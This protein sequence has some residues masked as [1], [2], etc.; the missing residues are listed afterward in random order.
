MTPSD[1]RPLL[2]SAPDV[3]R[4]ALPRAIETP[5]A[6][7]FAALARSRRRRA[8]HPKGRVSAAVL[9]VPGDPRL[10]APWQALDDA[11]AVVRRSRGGGLPE[12]WPDV[13]GIALRCGQ[14][15]LLLSSTLPLLPV[16]PFPFRDPVRCSY[17]SLAPYHCGDATGL[18]IGRFA[19]GGRE[20]RLHL[21]PLRGARIPLAVV[22]VG[23]T[24][25]DPAAERVRFDPWR[26]G[27]GL[28]PAG[29]VHRM[30][31]PAYLASRR[32]TYR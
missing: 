9:S 27:A 21:R 5:I 6:L 23:S 18:I 25:T 15:D 22:R 4:T 2:D 24:V 11:P 26:A 17:S 13:L 7:V 30:R 12:S 16:L 1:L 14:Q 28:T 19:A 3:R 32:Q 29:F 31:G 20:L 8:L 10:P